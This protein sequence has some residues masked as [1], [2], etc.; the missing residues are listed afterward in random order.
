MIARLPSLTRWLTQWVPPRLVAEAAAA[1]REAAEER[2]RLAR[3]EARA[4]RV[5]RMVAAHRLD[6][7][8]NHYGDRVRQALGGHP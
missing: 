2:R 8:E 4:A 6:R 1:E 5:D 3:I 7:T